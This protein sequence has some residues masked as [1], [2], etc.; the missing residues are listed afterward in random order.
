MGLR[1][2]GTEGWIDFTLGGRFQ[3]SSPSLETEVIGSNEIR[4]PV[5]NPERTFEEPGNYYADHIRNFLDSVKSRQEPLDPV[6]VGHRSATVCHLWNIAIQHKG[7]KL[8]WDPEREEV[9]NHEK[10]NS[11]RTRPARD[12][13]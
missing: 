9:I 2:E 11:M 12:W 7:T 3:A 10:A 4:L 13:V 5:S 1:F 8:A 6:E